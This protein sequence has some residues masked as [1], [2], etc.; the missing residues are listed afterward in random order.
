MHLL[1]SILFSSIS[2][3]IRLTAAAGCASQALLPA[4]SGPLEVD[5]GIMELIDYGR[6]QPFAPSV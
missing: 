4:P 2:I 5:L 3:S 1:L 6:M